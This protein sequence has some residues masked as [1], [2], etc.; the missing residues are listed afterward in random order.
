M[1]RALASDASSGGSNPPRSTH[2]ERGVAD[3]APLF[4][5]SKRYPWYYRHSGKEEEG[6]WKN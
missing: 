3:A 1:D 2:D 5:V 4:V 6:E